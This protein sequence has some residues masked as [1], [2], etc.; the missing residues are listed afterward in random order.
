MVIKNGTL[1]DGTGSPGKKTD[2]AIRGGKIAFIGRLDSLANCSTI[3]ASGCVVAPGFI[4]IH[5]HSDYLCFVAP[6]S[7][8]KVLDG[9]TMEVCGNCGSSPFPLSQ[10]T[11]Q[12]K[13]EGYSKYGLEIDWQDAPGFFRRVEASPSSINRA[14]LVG[15][16]SIRDFIM[17][18]DCRSPGSEELSR[19][20]EEVHLA[21]EAGALGLSSGLIY[22]PGCFSTT[23]ELLA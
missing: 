5:S 17:G 11:R 16:G 22:P 10:Q 18:Y 9:V 6:K 12:R 7:E 8:S 3:D 13:Q 21:M 1:I 15:H 23:E 20:R 2:L 4:D 19:M 14:F